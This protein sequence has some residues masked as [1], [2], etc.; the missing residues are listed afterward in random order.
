MKI[1]NLIL[2][3][4]ILCISLFSGCSDDDFQEV[5]GLCPVV[6]STNPVDGA[7]NVPLDRDD[8]RFV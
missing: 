4:V 3:F 7:I 5:I 2:P 8:Y 1:K 6:T